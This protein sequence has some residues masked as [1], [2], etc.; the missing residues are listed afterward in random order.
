MLPV[1]NCCEQTGT[2][3]LAGGNVLREAPFFNYQTVRAMRH[4]PLFFARG[5]ASQDR[6]GAGVDADIIKPRALSLE[7][8]RAWY[9]PSSCR[10]R[11]WVL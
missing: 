8:H 7:H 4:S 5:V 6:L 1:G 11:T 10:K 2:E 3:H 9:P